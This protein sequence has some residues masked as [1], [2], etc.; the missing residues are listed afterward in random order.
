VA[1]DTVLQLKQL[2]FQSNNLML[3]L[4]G[5]LFWQIICAAV[6]G[7]VA[8]Q[9]KF[10]IDLILVS[11]IGALVGGVIW[12]FV[13]FS[14][15]SRFL[16]WLRTGNVNEI[17]RL[18]GVWIQATDRTRRLL[19]EQSRQLENS[20]QRLED[21]LA[22]IQASPNG[23]ILLDKNGQIEWCNLT[24]ANHF[25]LNPKADIA[26]HI[27]NLVRDPNFARY[28]TAADYTNEVNIS[29]NNS[30]NRPI[31][32]AVRIHPYGLSKKLLLSNDI[33]ALD[34]AEHMRRDF[35]ANVSHEIRTPLTALSGFIETLQTLDLDANERGKYLNL[36]QQQSSRM[37]SLVSDLLT[38]S[39]LDGNPIPLAEVWTNADTLITACKLEATALKSELHDGAIE[40][41]DKTNLTFEIQTG[42]ELAGSQTELQSAMCNLVNNAVRYT[43]KDSN[44]HISLQALDRGG[45]IF[46]VTDSG[47]GISPEHL[48]RLTE[49]F[50]RVD[51]S[52][53]RESGG[54]GLGLAIVKHV[55][56][57]HGGELKIS[58]ILGKGSTFCFSLPEARVRLRKTTVSK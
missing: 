29:G 56:Q 47:L 12:A 13:D 1:Q 25:G 51:A 2:V 23:V 54:T 35:V 58:S 19:R 50:Y 10:D 41:S 5:I 32:L 15:S 24:A 37:Q 26:Q 49:R 16:E 39:K 34:A 42:I 22:A 7:L 8:F 21:F 20:N 14:E 52:R 33:T 6:F 43:A 31:R 36:M 45:V 55:V 40:H 46:S 57:R 30:L 17:P 38:L 3:R 44:I 27:G 11:L 9:F 4:L 53:S 48:P 28:F 18:T